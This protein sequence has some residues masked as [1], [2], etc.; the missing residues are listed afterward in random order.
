MKINKNSRIF[1][2]INPTLGT[3]HALIPWIDKFLVE[4]PYAGKY[5]VNDEEYVTLS[6]NR[7]HT[8]YHPSGDCLKCQRLLY[9]ERDVT[10]PP[11]REEPDA[12]LQKIFKMGDAVH[13]M[14]Q[15]WFSA[16]NDLDGFP[17][18]KGNEV[19][20]PDN[21]YSIGGYIDSVI[22][23][24]GA[25]TDTIIELKSISDYG[26]KSLSSPKPAHK[27]QVGCYMMAQELPEAIVLYVDKNTCDMKEFLVHPI[28]MQQT[29]MKWQQ[30]EEALD[31]KSVSGLPHSCEMGSK[32]WERCPARKIC[33]RRV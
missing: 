7:R 13:A 10:A 27:L 16:W 33:F 9:Y 14:L 17:E 12:H 21:P 22:R 23:F 1:S 3:E 31:K 11:M 5:V 29:L 18:C 32:E 2:S 26:F 24:P 28:D 4:H 6:K 30:V 19:R 15:A 8:H 20:I 25:D